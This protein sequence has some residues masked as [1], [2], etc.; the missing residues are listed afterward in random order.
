MLVGAVKRYGSGESAIVALDDVTIAFPASVV[1]EPGIHPLAPA[2][3]NALFASTQ[4]RIRSLPFS[5]HV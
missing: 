1:G 4:Q 5:D 3:A 2:L